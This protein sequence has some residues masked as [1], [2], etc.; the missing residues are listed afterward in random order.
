MRKRRLPEEYA[1]EFYKNPLQRLLGGGVTWEEFRARPVTRPAS[2]GP[3]QA[4]P[5][6]TGRVGGVPAGGA[7]P[8]R[9]VPGESAGGNGGAAAAPTP[10]RAGCGR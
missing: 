1:R 7:D 5:P 3:F 6:G 10:P 4:R 9:G 2:P 8:A